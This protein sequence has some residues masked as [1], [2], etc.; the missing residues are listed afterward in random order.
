MGLKAMPVWFFVFCVLCGGFAAWR[1]VKNGGFYVGG[2]KVRG[3][4][5]VVAGVII[6][7]AWG[8]TLAML[9]GFIPDHAP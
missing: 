9:L 3:P 1:G 8:L 2:A 5:I 7:I 6:L 4:V